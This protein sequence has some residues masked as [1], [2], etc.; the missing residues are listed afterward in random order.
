MNFGEATGWPTREAH[1]AEPPTG[2]ILGMRE[3]VRCSSVLPSG[4]SAYPP[5][6]TIVSIEVDLSG[7]R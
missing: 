6:G 5:S 4:S 7:M 2:G 3:S 1:V